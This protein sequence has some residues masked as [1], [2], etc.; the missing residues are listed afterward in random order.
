MAD[1]EIRPPLALHESVWDV[2]DGFSTDDEGN[3]VPERF[4]RSCRP[5]LHI[6]AAVPGECQC[7]K[8]WWDGEVPN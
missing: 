1:K 7:G 2:T 4:I 6:Y 3:I 8:H 5:G